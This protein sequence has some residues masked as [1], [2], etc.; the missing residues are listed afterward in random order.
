VAKRRRAPTKNGDRAL[1]PRAG[2][3]V[4]SQTPQDVRSGMQAGLRSGDVGSGAAKWRSRPSKNRHLPPFSSTF[5]AVFSGFFGGLAQ[6][7]ANCRAPKGMSLRFGGVLPIERSALRERRRPV[8][9]AFRRSRRPAPSA[10]L[11]AESETRAERSALTFAL[12]AAGY[13]RPA[14]ADRPC[15]CGDS[16]SRPGSARSRANP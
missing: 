10:Q 16:R 6:K 5:L 4:R 11:P 13:E 3:G 2:G 9:R 14:W 8:G 15:F 7:R 1:I 12:A